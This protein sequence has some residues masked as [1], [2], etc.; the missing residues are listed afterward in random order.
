[1]RSPMG[2]K[3]L[4]VLTKVFIQLRKFMAVFAR[5]PKK[6]GRNIEVTVLPRWP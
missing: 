5:P 6:G 2:K 4:A 1:M 3:K